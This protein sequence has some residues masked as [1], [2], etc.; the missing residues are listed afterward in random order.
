MTIRRGEPWGSA[1]AEVPAEAVV[2]TDDRSARLAVE[3]AL[4]RGTP[5]PP[6]ALRAGDLAR[7]M[8][9]P[10]PSHA[11]PDGVV[12][13]LPLDAVKATIDG[14]ERVFVAH[15]V[16]RRGWWRGPVVAAMNAEWLG[17]WDVA[18]RSHPDDGLVDVLEANLHLNDRL[19][20]RSRLPTG[21][22]LPHPSITVR[23]MAS[24]DLD[25]ARPLDIWLDGERLGRATA[26]SLTVLPDALVGYL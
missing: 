16:A 4:L 9:A 3:D 22:H 23:R 25:F 14:Q 15:F 19:K 24:V 6:L 17:R 10:M 12:M 11:R 2:V 5:P 1:V 20:A 7:T 18:P 8:G 13:R 26:A 21:T